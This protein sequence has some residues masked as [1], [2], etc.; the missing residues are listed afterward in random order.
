M[1]TAIE[2]GPYGIPPPQAI[3]H[4][5]II[6]GKACRMAFIEMPDV[7]STPE[8]AHDEAGEPEYWH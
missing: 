4:T 8:Q 2:L 3:V 6:N 7:P 1:V 5:L